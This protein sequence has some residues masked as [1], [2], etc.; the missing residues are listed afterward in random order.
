MRLLI[1]AFACL[2]F[3][4][5]NA[6]FTQG[7]TKD[8][9]AT[10]KIRLNPR[11]TITRSINI[12]SAYSLEK[13]TPHVFDQG[14]SDM[15]TAYSLALARTMVYA[16]NNNL[17]TKNKI[18]AEAYSPYYIYTKFKSSISGEFDGG[19]DMYFNKLNEYGYAKM[20]EIEYPH[21]Y[22]FTEKHL[23]NF[24][25]PSY[26][27]LDLQEIKSEKFDLI[28]CIYIDDVTQKEDRDE[29]V[30]LV[31]SEIINER[32]V[33]FGMNIYSTFGKWYD[34]FWTDTISDYCDHFIEGRKL[35]RKERYCNE[36]NWNPSGYCEKHKPEYYY[37]GHAMT[38]IA[39]N[40]EKYGGAFLVQNSWGRDWGTEGKIWISYDSFAKHAEDIQSLDKEPKSEFEEVNTTKEL[41]FPDK[42]LN[43]SVKD[44]TNS[45]DINWILFTPV[46]IQELPEKDLKAGKVSLPN[47]LTLLGN[48]EENLL[49]GQGELN[50]N[51]IYVYKGDFVDG[52]FDGEGQLMKYDKWGDIISHREGLY[53]SGDFIEGDVS[54]II[55]SSNPWDNRNGFTY[56]GH[57]KDDN[58]N[59]EGTLHHNQEEIIIDGVFE[60]GWPISGQ[61]SFYGDFYKYSGDIKNLQAHGKGVEKYD[62]KINTGQFVNGEFVY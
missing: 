50:L 35:F 22:P 26:I 23:W 54:E 5:S 34:D 51:N 25:V 27:D 2:L 57:F 1:T 45:L 19:L 13:Y 11:I 9:K 41:N 37:N 61:I 20:R 6:V 33:I 3:L 39:F 42:E 46:A 16:R 59:G 4:T 38:I 40:D 31:K 43:F 18:S 8:V 21:Y 29:L 24:S 48:L 10:E 44:F 49:N 55:M 58:Y 17:T 62:G 15:C 60:D 32:P 52:S 47:N 12:P 56:T 53:G 30:Q 28:N 14:A 36:E 7:L